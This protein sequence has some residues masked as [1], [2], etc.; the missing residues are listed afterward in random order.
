MAHAGTSSTNAKCSAHLAVCLSRAR[1]IKD[2][3]CVLKGYF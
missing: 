3:K 2:P 1:R